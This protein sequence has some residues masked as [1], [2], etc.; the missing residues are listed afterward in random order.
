MDTFT[1]RIAALH[2]FTHYGPGYRRGVAD[3]RAFITRD[4]ACTGEHD[5]LVAALRA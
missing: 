3:A 2:P 5:L 4:E 1:D